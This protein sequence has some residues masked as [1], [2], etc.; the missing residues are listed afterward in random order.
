MLDEYR[1]VLFSI[2]VWG[3]LADEAGAQLSLSLG[4]SFARTTARR[5]A[6]STMPNSRQYVLNPGMPQWWETLGSDSDLLQPA[7]QTY[8]R[9]RQ[10]QSSYSVDDEGYGLVA[11]EEQGT[12]ALLESFKR[13]TASQ[14]DG[15]PWYMDWF[16]GPDDAAMT[17]V[18]E[19]RSR[20]NLT[21]D[22][23]VTAAATMMGKA[24][25]AALAAYGKLG[26]SREQA[27][28]AAAAARKALRRFSPLCPECHN[29]LALAANSLKLALEEYD[30]ALWQ[31]RF[32][33]APALR[34]HW[35]YHPRRAMVRALLG[36]ASTLRKL[37]RWEEAWVAYQS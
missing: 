32:L 30:T 8:E 9:E 37:E 31:S 28:A 15:A 36:R 26:P 16:S 6:G 5:P 13:A 4:V 25:S 1:G 33:P 2:A 17:M 10:Q 19:L 14:D 11:A 20:L 21:S 35:A 18:G 12:V 3:G 22:E 34:D 7:V 29:V 27:R 23:E 24:A